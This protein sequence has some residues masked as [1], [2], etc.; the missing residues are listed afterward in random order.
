MANE[1]GLRTRAW[2]EENRRLVDKLSGG[3]LAYVG[4]PIRPDPPHAF[5]TLLLLAADKDGAIIDE[6]YKS[7]VAR[8]PTYIV[9]ELD[10]KLLGYFCPTRWRS[11]RLRRLRVSTVQGTIT[12]SLPV[13]AATPCLTTFSSTK[14]W[15]TG[16]H[17]YLGGLVGTAR[18]Q[19]SMVAAAS[20]PQSGFL[21]LKGSGMSKTSACRR[22]YGGVH[23][24]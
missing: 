15:T 7:M 19:R 17:T 11:L 23:T 21:Q 22:H 24:C 18:R 4:C 2:I 6:R 9:N 16:R 3:R 1:D 13:L 10:R 5:H 20:P 12:M 14:A 8:W